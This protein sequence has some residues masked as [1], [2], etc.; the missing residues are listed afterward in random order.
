VARVVNLLDEPA[1]AGLVM[2]LQDITDRKAVEE[3][4]T[5]QALHDALTGLANRS[6]LRDRIDLA[7]KRSQRSGCYPAV[8][9]LDLDG[10]KSVNDT[11]GH[12]AGDR[13]LVEVAS[14]L[15]GAIRAGD[16][17]SR[18]GGDEFAILIE[19]SNLDIHEA[20]TTADRVLQVL[21]VPVEIEGQLIGVSV[22]IGIALADESSTPTSLLRDADIA[23]YQAKSSG[24]GRWIDYHPAMRA[25]ALERFELTRDLHGALEADQFRLLYQP[26]VELR[27]GRTVGVEALLRWHHPTRG[28]IG[29][30]IFIPIAEANGQIVAIGEWVLHE[31]CRAAATWQPPAPGPRLSLAVNLSGRQLASDRFVDSVS[32]ALD[33]SGLPPS[34]LVLEITETTLISDPPA[35]A[36]RLHALRRLGVRLAI[37]DFGTGYS[38]LSYLRQF[39]IDILKID[40]SFIDTINEMDTAPAIVRGLLDLGQTLQLEVIAEGVEEH[41]QRLWL[42]DEDCRLGQGFL[43][44]K[45]MSEDEIAK[46]LGTRREVMDSGR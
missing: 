29:P 36:E 3:Q 34:A 11:L 26:V 43:F 28:V 15:N 33:T 46:H 40:K 42:E 24:A 38:S 14:R 21:G 44:A 30:D 20:S 2:N 37:D 13:M 22:S 17:V 6:L 32:A 8:L 31:A 9:Y 45:P 19:Q 41:H 12:D 35:V 27:T 16:T 7:L 39:P 10:F 18:L 25:D 1:V 4:L 5:H 23:M